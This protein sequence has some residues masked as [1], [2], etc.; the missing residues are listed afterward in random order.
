MVWPAVPEALKIPP[1][2][3]IVAVPVYVPDDVK[4][5]T[6]LPLIVAKPLE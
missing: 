5:S 4:P 3:A 6:V 2:P 1:K